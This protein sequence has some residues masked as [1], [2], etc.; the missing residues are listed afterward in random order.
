MA[1][2]FPL[3]VNGTIR[4]HLSRTVD[5]LTSL[6]GLAVTIRVLELLPPIPCW[7]KSGS[8]Q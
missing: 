2:G 4:W 8:P 6:V 3:H 7:Q 1:S 5:S